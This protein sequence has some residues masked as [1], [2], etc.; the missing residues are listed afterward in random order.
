MNLL[1]YNIE[2]FSG[3]SI[4]LIDYHRLIILSFFLKIKYIS[5]GCQRLHGIVINHGAYG[6]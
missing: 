6:N 4:S 5:L 1:F 2:L 3:I